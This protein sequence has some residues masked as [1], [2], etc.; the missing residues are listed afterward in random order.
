MIRT[1][2][3]EQILGPIRIRIGDDAVPSAEDAGV[4]GANETVLVPGDV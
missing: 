1:S 3:L 2:A 4:S